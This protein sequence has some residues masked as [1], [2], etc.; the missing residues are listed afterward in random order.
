MSV[1]T[2]MF[3]RDVKTA[4][5]MAFAGLIVAVEVAAFF[6]AVHYVAS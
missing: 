3:F 2:K 4:T 6:G 1:Y 5:E